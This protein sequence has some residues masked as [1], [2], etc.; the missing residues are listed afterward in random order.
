MTNGFN[1]RSLGIRQETKKICGWF[2]DCEPKIQISLSKATLWSFL[3]ETLQI[4]QA[5][6]THG[7]IYISRKT[8]SACCHQ[9]IKTFSRWVSQWILGRQKKKNPSSSNKSPLQ[10][11]TP[12]PFSYNHSD[13]LLGHILKTKLYRKTCPFCKIN[14]LF[15]RPP[16][17]FCRRFFNIESSVESNPSLVS[18]TT[19]N[20]TLLVAQ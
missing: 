13:F 3:G 4:N 11:G 16:F 15:P 12:P 2:G 19:K 8:C 6:L 18:V 20:N 14:K 5:S 9:E 10:W 17:L 7:Y 1:H